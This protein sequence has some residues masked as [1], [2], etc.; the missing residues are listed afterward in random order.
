L[1]LYIWKR[2]WYN[3]IVIKK[4]REQEPRKKSQK[5]FKKSLDR[6]L[7]LWYNIRAVR[8]WGAHHKRAALIKIKFE[9]N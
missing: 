3:N 5:K 7:N 1:P 4:E 9:R 6:P 8:E 2:K